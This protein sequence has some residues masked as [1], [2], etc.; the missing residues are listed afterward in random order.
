MKSGKSWGKTIKVEANA[1]CE[2]HAIDIN[3]WSRCSK[4]KH[5]YKTNLFYVMQGEL[6]V[7]VYKDGGM[8]DETLLQAGEWT[9]VPPNEYHEFQTRSMGCQAIELYWPEGIKDDIARL[10]QG[11]KLTPPYMPAVRTNSILRAEPEVLDE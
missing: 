11:G 3:P 7:L 6:I 2:M 8:V 1:F 4:H 10:D 5:S 9:S